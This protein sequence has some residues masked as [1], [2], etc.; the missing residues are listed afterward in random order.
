ME[1]P[2]IGCKGPF[3]RHMEGHSPKCGGFYSNCCEQHLYDVKKY[4]ESKGYV[5]KVIC[6]ECDGDGGCDKCVNGEE[7]PGWWIREL[8]K[9]NPVLR[10]QVLREFKHEILCTRVHI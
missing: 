10:E 2:C 4:W 1:Y 5:V 8:K 9:L 6:K 7:G 3:I